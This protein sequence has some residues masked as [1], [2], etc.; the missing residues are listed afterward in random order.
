MKEPTNIW[1]EVDGGGRYNLSVYS[2]HRA[3]FDLNDESDLEN[4]AET[5][6]DH[7]HSEHDGWEASWPLKIDLAASED[8]PVIATFEV[9]REYEPTFS[10]RKVAQQ[11]AQEGGEA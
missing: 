9:Y 4:A 10:A 11:A 3:K 1:Y 2:W 8:G 7:Y 6:A 5:S